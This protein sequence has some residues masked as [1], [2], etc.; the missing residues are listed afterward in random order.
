MFGTILEQRAIISLSGEETIDFLQGLISN[1]TRPLTEGE[2]VYAA[3]LSPQGR[4]LHDFFLVPW[5]G[6]ILIDVSRSRLPDLLARLKLYRLRSKIE[7]TPEDTL[8]VAALWN[9]KLDSEAINNDNYKIYTDPRLKELGVRLVGSKDSI[10][11]FFNQLVCEKVE[12]AAYK[13]MRISL[14]IPDTEDMIVEKSLLLE[15]GFEQLNGVN[16]SKGCYIGQEVTAR[17]KFRGQARRSFYQVK[18]SN[19][20]PEIGVPIMLGDKVAGELRTSCNN[21]GI[22]IIYNE[23]YEAVRNNNMALI[24]K[25]EK[26]DVSPA[27]WA[28]KL[29]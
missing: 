25:G 22:A 1:D 14:T 27:S 18:S 17:S 19:D 24:C 28:E 16:F 21:I 20:L 9:E 12:E 8:C 11:T 2:V 3:L 5:L 26:L 10:N 7:I 13:Y 23:D 6:K 29:E 4:F 15:C